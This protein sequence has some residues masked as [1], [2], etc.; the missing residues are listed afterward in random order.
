MMHK[1][2]YTK[3]PTRIKCLTSCEIVNGE[4]FFFIILNSRIS[5]SEQNR[6][7][8]EELKY[9]EE[10]DAYDTEEWT[11]RGQIPS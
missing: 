7:Y 8:I 10:K 6:A 11:V 1:V 5:V 9:I 4:P 2:I 3:M